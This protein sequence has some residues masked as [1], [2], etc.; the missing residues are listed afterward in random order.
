MSTINVDET[1]WYATGASA[2]VFSGHESFACRY[3]WLPKLYEA[4]QIDPEL[5][6]SDER[7]I[8]ALGLGRNMVKSIRFWGEA[9]GIMEIRG[10][11]ASATPFG[12]R[13]LDVATGLDPYLEDP[14]SLW[15]LHWRIASHAGLGAWVIAF[16]E[17]ADPEISRDRLV[18][19]VRARAVT[20]RG[21]ITTGTA[22]A[23]I[24]M[25]LRTYDAGKPSDGAVE[26]TLGCPLQELGLILVAT[27]AGRPSVRMSRGAR[28][29]LDAGAFAFALLDFWRGAAAGSRSLSVRSLM[30]ERRSP[31]SILRLDETAL[32]EQLL[33]VCART[34]AL[35]LRED[36]AG[37]TDLVATTDDHLE[38]LERLAWPNL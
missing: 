18:E 14:G 28:A 23:H 20:T 29:G 33:S 30:L 6:G 3:G 19:L 15:R 11:R 31:G 26:D 13:L 5:F 9:F 35:R 8:V 10:G 34:G 36:G 7:A 32:H 27:A 25:L 16:Q 37:S 17:N 24:D 21:S 1:Q 2:R 22:S 4:I 38:Q 12:E